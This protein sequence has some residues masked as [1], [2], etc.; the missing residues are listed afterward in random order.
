M[1]QLSKLQDR[2]RQLEIENIEKEAKIIE[3]NKI[4]ENNNKIIENLIPLK[5]IYSPGLP[6]IPFVKVCTEPTTHKSE[7][8]ND[9]LVN[10]NKQKF[11][12]IKN[13]KQFLNL[14]NLE[15]LSSQ[16]LE[17]VRESKY[18]IEFGDEGPIQ[19]LVGSYFFDIIRSTKLRYDLTIKDVLS[20][21]VGVE[22]DG[23]IDFEINHDGNLCEYIEDERFTYNDSEYDEILYDDYLNPQNKL[24]SHIKEHKKITSKEKEKK[25]K[26][27]IE[28]KRQTNKPDLFILMDSQNRPILAIEVKSPDENGEILNN[29]FVQAQ[30]FDYLV[31]LKSFYFNGVVYGILTT[32]KHWKICWLDDTNNSAISDRILKTVTAKKIILKNKIMYSSEIYQHNHKNLAKIIVSVIMKSYYAEIDPVNLFDVNRTYIKLTSENWMWKRYNLEQIEK[33]YQ[34]VNFRFPHDGIGAGNSKEFSILRYFKTNKMTKVRLVIS[35]AGNIIVIKQIL[36]EQIIQQEMDCW[37]SINNVT[38]V[39]IITLNSRPCLII[40]FVFNASYKYD[41]N[42]DKFVSYFDFDLKYWCFQ[43]R[44]VH[45]DIP[46]KLKKIQLQLEELNEKYQYKVD[47]VAK[48]AIKNAAS[49]KYVH[50]DLEFRHIALL[51]VFEDEDLVELKPVLIDFGIMLQ[52]IDEIDAENM[53]F[54][55]FQYI[56]SDVVFI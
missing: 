12:I 38:E 26:E 14:E 11:K 39:K 30:M 44:N 5:N 22:D 43:D 55:R 25:E 27:R 41:N 33:W 35:G 9:D 3:I 6:H 24:S 16:F 51:P 34:D 29:Q 18:V 47:E 40:P 28:K 49:Q 4:I 17:I 42:L 10:Y 48:I 20:V 54:S 21:G 1:D 31:S 52:N 56:S 19:G 13:L 23:R 37:I 2:I 8:F 7:H 45:S 53:M 32:M 50:Y 36:D 46:N 15:N